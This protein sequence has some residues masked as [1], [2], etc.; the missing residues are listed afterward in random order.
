MKR[1]S[2]SSTGTHWK[3][4]RTT[5][6]HMETMDPGEEVGGGGEGSGSMGA[7]TLAVD[8]AKASDMVQLTVV[9]T[10]AMQFGVFRKE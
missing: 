8:L 1:R 10:W 6:L 7:A 4:I 3:T 5:L 2:V 9:W